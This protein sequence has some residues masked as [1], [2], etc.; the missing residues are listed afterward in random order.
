MRTRIVH[1]A[2]LEEPKPRVA[3]KETPPPPPEAEVDPIVL[4]VLALAMLLGW[5][6]YHEETVVR[7]PSFSF[8]KTYKPNS[9]PLQ[10]WGLSMVK[11]FYD[12]VFGS[13]I[14]RFLS[15]PETGER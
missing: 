12:S 10:W 14:V 7:F 6:W 13:V 11:R 15:L 1:D 8:G 2:P 4:A 5:A 3:Q 9:L